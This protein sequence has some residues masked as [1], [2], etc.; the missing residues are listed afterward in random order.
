LEILERTSSNNVEVEIWDLGIE[1]SFMMDVKKLLNA[2]I[3]EFQ[4]AHHVSVE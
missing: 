1:M 4:M 2:R 3:P